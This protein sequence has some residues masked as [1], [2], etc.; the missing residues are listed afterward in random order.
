MD[1]FGC[2][3]WIRCLCLYLRYAL[4]CLPHGTLRGGFG[5]KA[6]VLC[7][8]TCYGLALAVGTAD[9]HVGFGTGRMG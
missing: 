7:R 4:V 6:W 2:I 5:F 8:R 9:V 1:A 3:Y